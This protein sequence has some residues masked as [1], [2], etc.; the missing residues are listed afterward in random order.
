MADRY[1]IEKRDY[2]GAEYSVVV[3]TAT[4]SDGKHLVVC[5]EPLTILDYTDGLIIK[6]QE[7]DAGKRLELIARLLNLFNDFHPGA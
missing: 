6:P 4:Q 1:Q 5:A 7:P 2:D 3:D